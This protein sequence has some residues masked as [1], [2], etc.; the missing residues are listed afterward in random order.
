M[1]AF[2]LGWV[3]ENL[4]DPTT[5]E[6]YYQR[7]VRIDPA[8]SEGA[9]RASLGWTTSEADIDQFLAA[10]ASVFAANASRGTQAAA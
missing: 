8:M 5:A 7:A 10:S 1:I 3:A 2:Q 4:D 6:R 9:L